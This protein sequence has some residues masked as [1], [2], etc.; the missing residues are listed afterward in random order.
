VVF[1]ASKGRESSYESP[2]V[3]GGVFSAAFADVVAN[4]RAKH[5]TNH[6]GVI[7]VSELFVAIKR[8]VSIEGYPVREAVA[9]Q[10]GRLEVG[11][12]TPWIARNKMLG[13]F[14]L[15]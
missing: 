5:D 6:N 4:E 8:K 2:T 11:T 1:A 10:E 15:F 3:R 14:A 13:D 12:Q 7:E 9:K